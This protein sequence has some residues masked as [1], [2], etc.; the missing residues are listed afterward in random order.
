[1]GAYFGGDGE[2]TL[3][4]P[5]YQGVASKESQDFIAL[6]GIYLRRSWSNRDYSL[7]ITS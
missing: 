5:I 6:N 2:K 7:P 3:A 4:V 1:L